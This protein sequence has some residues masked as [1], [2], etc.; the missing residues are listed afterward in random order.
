MAF[1]SVVLLQDI[2]LVFFFC[3]SLDEFDFADAQYEP[4][5]GNFNLKLGMEIAH[6]RMTRYCTNDNEFSS[7]TDK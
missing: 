4:I 6:L 3:S 5:E 1:S 7:Q 2:G